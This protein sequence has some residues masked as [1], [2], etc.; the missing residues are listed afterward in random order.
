MSIDLRAVLAA[1]SAWLRGEPGSARA[2]L[3]W[4]NLCGADL[5]VKSSDGAI[6]I[7]L[8]VLSLSVHRAVY[9]GDTGMVQIG[10]EQHSLERWLEAYEWIGYYHSYTD[11]QVLEYGKALHGLREVQS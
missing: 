10:C 2:N 3:S 9:C 4:A 1:H 7:D 8:R 5:Y 6:G 11:E